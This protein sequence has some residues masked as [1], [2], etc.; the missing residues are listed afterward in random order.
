MPTVDV[1]FRPGDRAYIQQLREHATVLA[2]SLPLSG[3][4]Q[5]E[6]GYWLN[7]EWKRVWLPAMELH[8]PTSQPR[9]A[10][11]LNASE[12]EHAPDWRC[13]G[14][15]AFR[16][17]AAEFAAEQMKT[18]KWFEVQIDEEELKP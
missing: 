13:E 8:Q 1:A 2:V 16:H 10:V 18:G 3:E 5:F 14:R 15:F 17:L 9:F 6:C 4:P 11:M 7:G 12:N